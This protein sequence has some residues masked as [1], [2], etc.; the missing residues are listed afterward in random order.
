MIP[1]TKKI[2]LKGKKR[3]HLR[4][5]VFERDSWMCQCPY[6]KKKSRLD[7]FPHHI[8]YKSHMGQDILE[9]L[10]SICI[11]CHTRIHRKGNLKVKI[12]DNSNPY[13]LVLEWREGYQK[14]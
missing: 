2:R 10:V 7:K 11:D 8:I 13:N 5:E 3:D 9:N 12:I 6:C 4:D 1:K 14:T